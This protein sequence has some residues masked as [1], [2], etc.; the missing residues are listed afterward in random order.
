MRLDAPG[1]DMVELLSAPLRDDPGGVAIA[2]AI[3]PAMREFLGA[4]P[5]AS[6]L[7]NVANLPEPILDELAR[8]LNVPWYDSGADIE[9]KR[10][11]ILTS[12][13]IN[14]RLGTPWAVATVAAMYFGTATVEEWFQY[15][16]AP[17]HFR[18][19]TDNLDAVTAYDAIFR[20]LIQRTKNVR[21]VFEGVWI[22]YQTP[23]TQVYAGT[24]VQ[25][26]ALI[27]IQMDGGRLT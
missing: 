11:A 6:L 17:Y 12:D 10:E 27:T 5:N 18:V 23:D 20:E 3:T 15:A 19:R 21:S 13:L 22:D 2:R 16:G 14:M 24:A 25:T 9:I 7:P 4:I 1:L 26:A 8:D